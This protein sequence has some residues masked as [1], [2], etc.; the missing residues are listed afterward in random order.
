MEK[1][2]EDKK[3][4]ILNIAE[5]VFSE[6][7]YEGASTRLLANEACVNMAMISYYFGSKDGLLKAVLERRIAGLRKELEEVRDQDIVSWKKISMVI[8]VYL[9]RVLSN[10]CFY[11]LINRELSLAQRSELGEFISDSIMRNVHV[12]KEVIEEGIQN[13][14]FNPV[15]V[16]MTIASILGTM[17]YMVNSSQVASKMLDKDFLDPEVVQHEIRPRIKQYLLDYLKAYLLKN[18]SENK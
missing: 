5:K 16:E 3:E 2:K 7:G 15:D 10:N 1:R 8:D 14:S 13:G 9:N 11:R 12:F 6:Y 17:Y 18:E 4:H